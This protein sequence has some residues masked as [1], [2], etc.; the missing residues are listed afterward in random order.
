ME[1]VLPRSISS[2]SID[3][4]RTGPYEEKQLIKKVASKVSNKEKRRKE[5]KESK[6]RT[7]RTVD[8]KE[9]NAWID[10]IAKAKTLATQ[11]NVDFRFVT[12][13][14]EGGMT[15]EDITFCLQH[16]VTRDTLSHCISFKMTAQDIVNFHYQGQQH[17]AP[18]PSRA[19]TQPERKLSQ[20]VSRNRR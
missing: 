7:C 14:L 5:R 18:P 6:Y 10:N 19:A 11:F 9:E 1:K 13:W 15:S 8:Q 17:L 12:L 16:G 2:T 20:W 3:T 4:V